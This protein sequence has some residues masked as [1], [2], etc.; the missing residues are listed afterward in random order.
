MNQILDMREKRVNLWNA[1]KAFL[2]SRRAEDGTLS[3]EDASTYEKMEADVIRM[4]KEID[5]LERQEILDLEFD[6]PTSRPLISA[7]EPLDRKPASGRSSDDYRSAFWRVIR[8]KSVPHEVLNAL[9][10]GEESEGGYT[11]PDEFEHTLVEALQ[12][13]NILRGAVHVITTSSGDRKIPLVTN[14]GGAFWV[15]EEAVI[16]ESDDAFG[17]ITLSAHKVGCMIRISEE[18]LRDSAFDL[19]SYIMREFARRVGAAEEEAIL[20]GDGSHKPT[21]LL[22]ATLGAQTGVT[23]AAVAAITADE[24]IDLQHSLK[25][26]YRRK[27]CYI[28]NDATIKLLRKLKDGNGQYLWQ[29]GL[30]V[31]QPDTLLNQ[32]VLTSNY[33]PMPTAGNAAIL[34]GDL[35]YYWLADREGRSLQRRNELYAATDQVGFKI[36]QRVDGRLILREAAKTLTMKAS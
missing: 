5:R 17:Q 35:S 3:V 26:G 15:E 11:V 32:R 7:P 2:D 10:I 4:G 27:A 22:H 23:T 25:S 19:A 9:Q 18:L 20:T 8:Q 24:L 31:G 30:L 33:M 16:P 34:Y 12:D 14:K 13:E 6:R 36:T 1:T 28:M 21:G 29:P